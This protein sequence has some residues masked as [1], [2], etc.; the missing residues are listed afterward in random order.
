MEIP[1]KKHSCEV[2]RWT[3]V[4]KIGG[5]TEMRVWK[6]GGVCWEGGKEVG[7]QVL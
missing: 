6:C 1:G 2:I 3:I 7:L 5:R 4:L